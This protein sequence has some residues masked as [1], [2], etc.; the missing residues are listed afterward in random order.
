MSII[1]LKRILLAGLAGGFV[2]NL[3]DTPWSILMMVPRNQVFLEAHGLV[4]SPLTG[5]WFL[6]THF[7]FVT[8]IAWVYAIARNSYGKSTWTALAAGAAL[9]IANRMFGFGNVLVGTIPL[10][11][12]WGFSASFVLG[13]FL[14]T[15]AAAR[16]IDGGKNEAMDHDTA[17]AQKK[18]AQVAQGGP[19]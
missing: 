10:D 11:V 2:L 8:V 18:P 9:L 12:F 17:D 19:K 15:F 13:T 14:A 7:V 3:I 1:S 5:P 16:V 4:T 6:L